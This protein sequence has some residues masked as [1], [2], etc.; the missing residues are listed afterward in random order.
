MV[1]SLQLQ[2]TSWELITFYF[3]NL[4]Q[5]RLSHGWLVSI[6]GVFP[7]RYGEP[8]CSLP[9]PLPSA[10]GMCQTQPCGPTF[11]ARTSV[12]WVAEPAGRQIL[13]PSASWVVFLIPLI[14]DCSVPDLFICFVHLNR[15]FERFWPAVSSPAEGPKGRAPSLGSGLI[16]RMHG[17]NLQ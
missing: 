11:F 4:V 2:A 12:H 8:L 6:W 15:A 9:A 14:W 3:K 10:P 7:S 16:K 5:S 17:Q 1:F 13:Q